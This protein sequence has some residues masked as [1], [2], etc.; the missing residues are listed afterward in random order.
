MKIAFCIKT[1]CYSTPASAGYFRGISEE[2]F[3]FSGYA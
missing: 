3:S 1:K 2:D